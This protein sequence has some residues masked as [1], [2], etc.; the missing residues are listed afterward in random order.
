[1]RNTSRKSRSTV[2]SNT[3]KVIASDQSVSTRGGTVTLQTGSKP[4]SVQ[5]GVPKVKPKE[6]KF[7]H[8]NLKRLQAS[9]NLS[10]KSLL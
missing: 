2:T 3:L 5:I 7:S 4:L 6:A 9:T 10:D 8:E 1:M